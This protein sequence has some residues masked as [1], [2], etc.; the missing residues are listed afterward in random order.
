MKEERKKIEEKADILKALSS[1]ARLCLVKTI[2]TEGERNVTH[3]ADCMDMSQSNI[4]Q[5]LAKLRDLKILTTRKEANRVFYDCERE[6]VKKIV[7]C[8]FECEKEKE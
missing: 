7:N 1:P 5:H 3:F 8:L 4:S 2:I 6:D